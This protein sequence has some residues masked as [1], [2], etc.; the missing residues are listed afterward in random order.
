MNRLRWGTDGKGR[1]ISD[2]TQYFQNFSAKLRLV[3][4][5]RR[6]QVGVLTQ[7]FP[8]LNDI[9]ESLLAQVIDPVEELVPLIEGGPN[10]P[11]EKLPAII[12][13]GPLPL[14]DTDEE[15]WMARFKGL[16]VAN[17][18]IASSFGTSVGG[19]FDNWLVV[20]L[21]GAVA[22]AVIGI[23]YRWMLLPT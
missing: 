17:T 13:G 22:G 3:V 21:T 6:V 9:L 23:G 18:N 20:M 1:L 8:G 16:N 12:A 11:A 14:T 10:Q 2:L 19:L 5:S 4:V 7:D 15:E